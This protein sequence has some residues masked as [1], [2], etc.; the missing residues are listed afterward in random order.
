M[1]RLFLLGLFFPLFL[2]ADQCYL[3]AQDH[4]EAIPMKVA[5]ER[6]NIDAFYKGVDV[7][8]SADIPNDVDGAVVKIQGEDEQTILNRK[9]KVSIFWLNTAEVTVT[10]APAIY[11]LN[12]SSPLDDFCASNEQKE[13]VLGYAALKRRIIIDC[14]DGLSGSEFDE[15][16]KLKEHNGSYQRAFTAELQPAPDGNAKLSALLHIPPLMPSGDHRIRLYCFK[17]FALIGQS[18]AMLRVEK[19]G[20]PNYL[21]SLAHDHPAVY[22]LLAIAIA[23]VT[24]IIMGVIFSARTRRRQ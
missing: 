7:T 3:F 9:G 21:Y 11:M 8:I 18:S 22:G 23:M 4:I 15:F 1:R 19:V 10:N 24:G 13:L 20:V 2:L 12:A 16:I 17:N 6:V 14:E 5:P